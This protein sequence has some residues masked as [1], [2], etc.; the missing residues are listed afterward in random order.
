MGGQR[1]PILKRGNVKQFNHRLYVAVG[2]TLLGLS[3]HALAG[4]IGTATI[5]NC[6]PGGGVTISATSVTWLPSAGLNEGCITTGPPTSISYSGG[7][8]TSGAGTINDLT[9]PV[10]ATNPFLV[11]AGGVLDFSLTAFAPA[12]PTDG[13]CSTTAALAAGHSCI[14]AAGS[15]FLFTSDGATTSIEFTTLGVITDSGNSSTTPYQG[16]FTEQLITNTA[17]L[18]ATIDGGGSITNT[19]S[20]TI[21]AVGAPEPATLVG[22]SV[23]LVLI[24]IRRQRV[25]PR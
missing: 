24:G 11:L 14:T 17:A 19:Y 10:G 18:A 23:G 21:V 15:P 20:A 8:F 3:S 9:F 2:I 22:L 5:T 4:P 6:T 16:I 7:T 12:L 13:V 1:T 25:G